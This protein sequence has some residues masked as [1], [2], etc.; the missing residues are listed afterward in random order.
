MNLEQLEQLKTALALVK[1]I[2]VTEELIARYREAGE[3]IISLPPDDEDPA[4]FLFDGQ[5]KLT[6][7][8]IGDHIVTVL[9]RRVAAIE[10]SLRDLG[11]SP[12]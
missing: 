2:E 7:E 4:G 12:P 8:E 6:T 1:D 9:E 10:A 11:V 5:I 3:V